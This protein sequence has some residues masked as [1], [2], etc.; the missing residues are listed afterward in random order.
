MRRPA[1][2]TFDALELLVYNR[3]WAVSLGFA[4]SVLSVVARRAEGQRVRLEELEAVLAEG[5]V[6]YAGENDPKAAATAGGARAEEQGYTITQEGV[7]V[8][9]V[10]GALV[11]RT[12]MKSSSG[13]ETSYEEVDEA[14][15]AAFADPLARSVLL[16]ID[17]P[18]G[19]VDGC[20]ELCTRLREM[21]DAYAKPLAAYADGCA[22][23]AA[24][25]IG[26]CADPGLFFAA[27][28][29]VTG[30]IG[31]IM[32]V[33]DE[34]A[35]WE[36]MGVRHTIIQ[37]GAFKSAGSPLKPMTDDERAYLQKLV[38]DTNAMFVA[39]VAAS[40]GLSAEA[41]I[42]TQAR[43]YLADAAVAAGLIDHAASFEDALDALSAN[44]A[45]SS[46]ALGASTMPGLTNARKGSARAAVLAAAANK[47][48]TPAPRAE[49]DPGDETDP[50]KDAP[51][52]EKPSFPP[53]EDVTAEQLEEA[54]PNHTKTLREKGGAAPGGAEPSEN[55]A[56]SVE[57][58]EAAFPEATPAFI[59]GQFKA[60]ATMVA[61]ARA[62]AAEA[63]AQ[64]KAAKEEA[65]TAR[66]AAI[67]AGGGNA[68]DP[69]KLSPAPS[70]AGAGRFPGA[71]G[72]DASADWDANPDIQAWWKAKYGA[73]ASKRSFVA[74]AKERG[75]AKADGYLAQMRTAGAGLLNHVA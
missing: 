41:V 58:L 51:A 13:D 3:P 57:Q 20:F 17:S 75:T 30:S 35:M 69:L 65:A 52:P 73:A 9:P 22:C 45:G 67:D 68:P 46:P 72:A 54:Y 1:S 38:N 24:Y 8:V 29:A 34:S 49:G 60:K 37:A 36:A 26:C 53:E 2:I 32:A 5:R 14:A 15:S 16:D 62:Y 10:C 6:G 18:G 42:G 59:L 25:A 4:R 47:P 19:A 43:V 21:A 66:K 50:M 33:A 48:A 64:V 63:T 7:A 70:S 40:R 27:P 61:A 39:H 31:V 55:A 23:S 28:S 71:T 74:W 11:K 12:S 56:A 44:P